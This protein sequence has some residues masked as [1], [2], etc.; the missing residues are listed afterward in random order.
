MYREKKGGTDNNRTKNRGRGE[1]RKYGIGKRKSGM[2]TSE[3]E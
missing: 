1:T 2:K 3:G